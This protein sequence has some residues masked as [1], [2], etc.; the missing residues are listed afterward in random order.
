M[1]KPLR[2]IGTFVDFLIKKLDPEPSD[3]GDAYT[4]DD[5]RDGSKMMV[6]GDLGGW[7]IP[8]RDESLPRREPRSGSYEESP[9]Q[10]RKPAHEE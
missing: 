7:K 3:L 9:N 4:S 5:G 2:A 1:L 10:W 8:D 6:A